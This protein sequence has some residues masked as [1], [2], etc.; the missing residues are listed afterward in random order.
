MAYGSH[1]LLKRQ[2]TQRPPPNLVCMSFTCSVEGSVLAIEQVQPLGCQIFFPNPPALGTG[3]RR[4]QKRW[5]VDLFAVCTSSQDLADVSDLD[6]SLRRG[7]GS[8]CSCAIW[9]ELLG[10][11]TRL[12]VGSISS[13][14][15]CISEPRRAGDT[16][17]HEGPS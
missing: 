12:E 4:P 15:P 1:V 8:M 5:P 16:M 17:V 10:G 3:Y 6:V 14:G 11:S 9:V 7:L 13:I 2:S